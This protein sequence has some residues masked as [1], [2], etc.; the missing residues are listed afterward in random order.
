MRHSCKAAVVLLLLS[1]SMGFSVFADSFNPLTAAGVA[2]ANRSADE[3]PLDEIQQFVSIYS[4]VKTHYVAEK[5]DEQLFEQAIQGL[6]SGLDRYSRYLNPEQYQAL[7]QYTE[8]DLA[9]VDFNIRYVPALQQWQLHA[10]RPESDAYAAGLR[11]GQELIKLE[12]QSVNQLPIDQVPKLLLGAIGSSLSLQVQPQTVLS[13]LSSTTLT[14][15]FKSPLKAASKDASIETSQQSSLKPPFKV[16]TTDP[17]VHR[18]INLLRSVKVNADVQ[19]E[20][21]SNQV[22]WIQVSVFQQDTAT[23]IKHLIELYSARA[24][25]AVLI[26]LRNN[27]GGL[28]SAAVESADLFLNKGI[29][30][31]TKSRSEGNQQFQALP[32]HDFPK[33]KLGVLINAR[34]ASA[35]EVFAAAMQSQQRALLI[36]ERSYG[37]GVVQKLFPLPNGAAIQMTVSHYYTPKGEMIDGKGIQPHVEWIIQPQMTEAAYVLQAADILLQQ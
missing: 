34:S 7:L 21:L 4:L 12:Q 37:K 32:S 31:S 16:P 13:M 25:K 2:D 1:S 9:T 11:N 5:T 35:A 17:L 8:G 33:L 6:V 26:D 23:Q 19:A 10:I 30:V 27:P 3:L 29:I 20:L 15:Q 24:P 28:L 22:L 14:N 18:S 36:G